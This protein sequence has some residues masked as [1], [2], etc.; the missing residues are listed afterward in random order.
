MTGTHEP[1]SSTRPTGDPLYLGIAAGI[2]ILVGVLVLAFGIVRAPA[3]DG[4][5]DTQR[6]DLSGGIAWT[7]FNDREGCAD[8]IVAS[9]E[10][11][12]HSLVCDD[13]LNQVV[14]W[15]DEGIVTVSYWED[16]DRLEVRD[17]S[18]GEIQSTETVRNGWYEGTDKDSGYS[19]RRENGVLT[20]SDS[21]GHT[22]WSVEADARY[23]IGQAI[24]S[25]P[26][27]SWV[28]FTDSAERLL[29]ARTDG[30]EPPAIWATGVTDWSWVDL[31]WEG[32][33]TSPSLP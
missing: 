28:A 29:V 20:L 1:V 2:V 9:P 27:G 10:N 14:G 16:G 31:V 21:S 19:A 25:S 12:Y 3:L 26:D 7:Q 8:L 11:A 30:T 17:P 15:T 18:T 13:Q 5:T 23:E 22:I 32:T 6:T 24:V 33:E 4:L